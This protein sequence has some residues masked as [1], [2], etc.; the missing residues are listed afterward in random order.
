MKILQIIPTLRPGGA[1]RFVCEIATSLNKRK[2]I[3]CNILTLHNITED[4]TLYPTIKDCNIKV[5]SFR[6]NNIFDKIAIIYK[7]YKFIKNGKYDVVHS[8]SAAIKYIILSVLL[9]KKIKFVA[10]IHSEAKRE[11]GKGFEKFV[12]KFMFKHNLCIPVT[13][14]KESL[15]SFESFY[16]KTTVMI[17]NGVSS[18]NGTADTKI[19]KGK[20]EI[21]F[22]HPASCQPVKNQELLFKSFAELKNKY[23]NIRL[24]WYGSNKAYKE[25]FDSLTPFFSDR[26]GIE[27][28]GIHSNIRSALMVADAMC[29]SS[30]MEGLPMTIIEAFSVGCPALCTPVGGCRNIISNGINGFLSESNSMEDYIKMLEKFILLSKDKKTGMRNNALNTFEA[31]HIDNT[32]AKYIEVYNS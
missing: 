4:D 26:N 9:L 27:Y 14:S 2:D 16:K 22:I 3:E 1:E 8:H 18:F 15:A 28:G 7:I 13:I 25:L 29:L 5:H 19:N 23:R 30:K 24:I 6:I 11:A 32:V 20:D 12:K 31:Y 10:T 17:P 21:L